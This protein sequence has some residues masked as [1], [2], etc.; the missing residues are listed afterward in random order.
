MEEQHKCRTCGMPYYSEKRARNCEQDHAN[1][2]HK[3][4]DE[5]RFYY[6]LEGSG[7]DKK[8]PHT[9]NIFISAASL[10][11]RKKEEFRHPKLPAHQKFMLDCG[12]FS[13]FDKFELEEYP[14]DSKQLAHLA[15]DIR[16][17]YVATI[18]Y[19]CEPELLEQKGWTV[20]DNIQ[21]TVEN[22]EKCLSQSIPGDWLPVIQGFRPEQYKHCIDLME[23]KDVI[24]PYMAVGSVCARSSV[25]DMSEVIRTV[26]GYLKKKGYEVDLHFFGLSINALKRSGNYSRI[27]STD[28]T[29]WKWNQDPAEKDGCRMPR[30]EKDKL[31]N[32]PGYRAKVNSIKTQNQA[33]RTLS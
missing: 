25:K 31:E 22:A 17:D 11:S 9:E 7:T 32:F 29:A 20:E 12:G 33:Q 30:H 16:P 28:S 6:G 24:R 26:H 14:F 21:R 2:R 4:K 10:W 8:L 5:L 18:D 23:E 3:F 19:P 1:E 27:Y 15:R 13:F